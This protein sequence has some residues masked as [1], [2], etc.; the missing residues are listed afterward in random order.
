MRVLLYSAVLYLLGI[1]I[2]LYVKPK[3]MFHHNGRWKEFGINGTDTTYLPFWLFCIIW[4][5]AAYAIVRTFVSDEVVQSGGV[6]IVSVQPRNSVR[7]L[8]EGISPLPVSVPPP[9]SP[10]G[11]PGYYKLDENV[12]KEKG[13][14]LYIYIGPERPSDLN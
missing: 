7:P 2:V 9:N 3:Q 6:E 5:V 8:T 12:L 4:A 14:P 11:Q 13:T 1:T 10:E